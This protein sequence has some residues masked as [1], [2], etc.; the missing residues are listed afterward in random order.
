LKTTIE[1]DMPE[2]IQ[3]APTSKLKEAE[4]TLASL[5]IIKEE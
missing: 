2:H 1:E 5:L 4:H 3:D